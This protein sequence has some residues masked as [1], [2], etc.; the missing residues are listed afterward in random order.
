MNGIELKKEEAAFY[1]NQAELNLKAIEG[2]ILI[3]EDERICLII[4]RYFLK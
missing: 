1:F 2:N 3:K 4:H